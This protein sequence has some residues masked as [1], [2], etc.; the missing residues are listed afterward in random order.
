M[1]DKG[2]KKLPLA[3]ENKLSGRTTQDDDP[4]AWRATWLVSVEMV[5]LV[6]WEPVQ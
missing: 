3:E 5:A 4:R 6:T 1:R 2:T